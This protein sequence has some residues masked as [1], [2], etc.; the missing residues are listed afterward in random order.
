MM[1][2]SQMLDE[3][4]KT[5]KVFFKQLHNKKNFLIVL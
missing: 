4:L 2:A 5:M 3:N 1:K